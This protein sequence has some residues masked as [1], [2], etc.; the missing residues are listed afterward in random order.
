MRQGHDPGHHNAN[1]DQGN[2]HGEA[3]PQPISVTHIVTASQA[4]R[5]RVEQRRNSAAADAFMAVMG[6]M[7]CQPG[8]HC[9]D[10]QEV[11]TGHSPGHVPH[12]PLSPQQVQQALAAGLSLAHLQSPQVMTSPSLG[13]NLGL[14]R[15]EQGQLAVSESAEQC[16]TS[17][18]RSA[19]RFGRHDGTQTQLTMAVTDGSRCIWRANKRGMP[20]LSDEQAAAQMCSRHGCVSGHNGHMLMS[21]G[22]GQREAAMRAASGEPRQVARSLVHGCSTGGYNL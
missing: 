22:D 15:D 21:P 18:Q 14:Y 4:S 11:S 7:A 1:D 17:S 3:D 10:P 19:T 6:S 9:T 13:F 16:I 8:F 12:P 20:N 2:E 5:E